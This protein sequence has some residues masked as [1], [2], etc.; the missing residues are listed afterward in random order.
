MN[1]SGLVLDPDAQPSMVRFEALMKANAKFRQSWEQD[2]RDM[3]DT[4]P[5]A[6]DFSLANMAIRAGWPDQEVVNL[7]IYWRRKHGH[8]LKLRENYYAITLA[9]AKEPIEMDE[10]EEQMKEAL[11]HPP[12]DQDE[13]LKDSLSILLGVDILRIQKYLGDPPIYY[14][15]TLQGNITLGEIRAI[16]SQ[17]KFRDAV[18]A[19]TGVMIA[20]A[21]RK[22]WEA[23]VQAMLTACEEVDLGDHSHPAQETRRWLDEYLLEKPPREEMEWEKGAEA[24]MP[25]LR[26]ERTY[27]FLENFRRW[28]EMTRSEQMTSRALAQRVRQAGALPETIGVRVGT[29][30]TTRSCWAL[31]LEFWYQGQHRNGGTPE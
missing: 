8:D 4:S 5:S 27:I 18:A 22:V 2:R 17:T 7:M 28:L 26:N 24:K 21:P 11:S 10:A 13:V 30:K 23:R 1:G 31:P 19:A 20:G 12:E 14:M 15:H 16:T 29:A 6:Y 9:K 3:A 25:F